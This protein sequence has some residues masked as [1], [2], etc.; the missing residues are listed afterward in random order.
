MDAQ[1]SDFSELVKNK[2][3]LLIDDDQYIRNSLTYY[4]KKKTLAFAA[5]ENAE[6]ALELLKHELF[7]IV[8]LFWVKTFPTPATSSEMEFIVWVP[9]SPVT[10]T[11]RLFRFMDLI[12]ERYGSISALEESVR[13][14]VL[15]KLTAATEPAV[16]ADFVPT[17]TT[18]M[19][20]VRSVAISMVF[21]S[22]SNSH[23][24]RRI[25]RKKNEIILV[26]IVLS[27]IGYQFWI[28]R[29]SI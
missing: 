11:T 7:D 14:W 2:K 29:F 27:I 25:V 13:S 19:S 26:F 3:I 22:L 1:N 20:A 21:A 24:A 4:F 9:V 10:V 5:L 23:P 6:E 28:N 17:T 16:S 15:V 12:F 18:G 8:I